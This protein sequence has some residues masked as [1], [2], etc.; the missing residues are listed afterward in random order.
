MTINEFL[1]LL[2][3]DLELD[4]EPVWDK[5]SVTDLTGD[6]GLHYDVMIDVFG[7]D[8][9]NIKGYSTV[10][11]ENE[12]SFKISSGP[13]HDLYFDSYN[14]TDSIEWWFWIDP[15]FIEYV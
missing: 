2:G 8:Y 3:I 7:E 15:D 6:Y 11:T 14:S 12:W 9:I 10:E 4:R 5:V 13:D 1:H